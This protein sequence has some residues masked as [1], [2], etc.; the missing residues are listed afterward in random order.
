MLQICFPTFKLCL[1]VLNCSQALRKFGL[2]L[3][4]EMWDPEKLTPDLYLE[5]K[6]EPDPGSVTL[7][8][9]VVV[10]SVPPPPPLC[11]HVVTG[12]GACLLLPRLLSEYRSLQCIQI[13]ASN[14]L[15]M[16]NLH[17]FTC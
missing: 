8:I 6:K 4:P 9:R 1:I 11:S 12:G 15:S 16:H 3:G 13:L 10:V 17:I 5:I 14:V 2:D 7:P